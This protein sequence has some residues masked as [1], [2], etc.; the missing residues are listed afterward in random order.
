[1]RAV[2]H[3]SVSRTASGAINDAIGFKRD[4]RAWRN[5]L[6]EGARRF[7]KT[8]IVFWFAVGSHL[9]SCSLADLWPAAGE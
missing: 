3:D 2:E 5:L 1:M 6:G 8:F 4:L 9:Q 7:G